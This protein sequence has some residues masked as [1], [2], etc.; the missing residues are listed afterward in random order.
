MSK[1]I[2]EINQFN[3]CLKVVLCKPAAEPEQTFKNKFIS[4]LFSFMSSSF[5]SLWMEPAEKP[6]AKGNKSFSV[7]RCARC[8]GPWEGFVTSLS[9]SHSSPLL[10][11]RH[12]PKGRLLSVQTDSN[13]S[14][15]NLNS[16]F[17][18]A[19]RTEAHCS[20]SG[21]KVLFCFHAE[22]HIYLFF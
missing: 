2:A 3:Q 8:S 1:T 18:T 15:L 20:Y 9:A 13:R 16:P 17:C 5:S 22:P 19:E 7:L 12:F 21:L 4:G 10:P 11:V 6:A 14:V